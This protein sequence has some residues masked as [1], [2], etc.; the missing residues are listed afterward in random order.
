MTIIAL[1]A[2]L[3]VG[4]IAGVVEA[5]RVIAA[6]HEAEA[7]VHQKIDALEGKLREKL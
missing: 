5:N 3:C 2:V 1:V 6:I 4:F 7:T